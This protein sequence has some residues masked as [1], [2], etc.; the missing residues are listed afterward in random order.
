MNTELK[1][2]RGGG[3]TFWLR[4]HYAEVKSYYLI[5]GAEATLKQY[6]MK[7]DTL[8]RFLSNDDPAIKTARI[9]ESDRWVLNIANAGLAEMR[10]RLRDL[11]EWKEHVEPLLN[12]TEDLLR[13]ITRPPRVEE[14]GLVFNDYLFKQIQYNTTKQTNNQTC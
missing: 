10:G 4:N 2:L 7:P 3:K 5:N 11:E 13:V 12:L 8:E 14:K 1:G 6:N 9:S